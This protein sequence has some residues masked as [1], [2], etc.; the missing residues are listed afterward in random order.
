LV[1]F[2]PPLWQVAIVSDR[3]GSKEGPKFGI[4]VYTYVRLTGRSF[5]LG[6]V[7]KVDRH[8]STDAGKESPRLCG[9][10]GSRTLVFTV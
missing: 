1:F 2:S 9:W 3:M 6:K 7:G 5:T 8:G 10:V 4:Y